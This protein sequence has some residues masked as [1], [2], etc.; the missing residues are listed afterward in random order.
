[1][2]NAQI[3]NVCDENGKVIWYRFLRDGHG[4]GMTSRD[5]IADGTQH[6]IIEMLAEA[7]DQARAEISA[8][9]V[10]NVVSDIG[11]TSTQV[12]HRVPM[13]IGGH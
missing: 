1:M 3:V 4:G 9:D 6:G 5:Y 12:N 8:L 13:S 10:A 11:A 7:L 2:K